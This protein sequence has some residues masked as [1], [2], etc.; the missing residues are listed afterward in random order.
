MN[1]KEKEILK[2]LQSDFP[3]V[4]NP[5][6][7]LAKRIGL[8][9]KQLIAKIKKFK[10][11]KIIRRVGAVTSAKHLGYK[12]LLIAACVKPQFVEKT[13][14]FISSF[15]NVTHNYLRKAEYN[16]WFTFSAK[17]KKEI[18]AFIDNLKKRRGVEE[19]LCLPATQTFKIKAEF[20]F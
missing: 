20:K 18:T 9:P 10:Q 15:E 14:L 11:E 1:Q 17:T 5:Y 6:Q 3:V 7:V 13:A 19:V 2:I 4:E 8:S 16:L 12:S